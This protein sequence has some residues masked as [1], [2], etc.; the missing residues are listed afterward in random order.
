MNI[1]F[2]F[3]K[4][5]PIKIFSAEVTTKYFEYLSD[6]DIYNIYAVYED[7]FKLFDYTFKL[8]NISLPL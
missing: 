7:D 2:G 8:R 4:Y 1:D 6:K 5:I 3:P